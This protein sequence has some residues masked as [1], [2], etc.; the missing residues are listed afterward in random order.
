MILTYA[1]KNKF[2]PSMVQLK[3]KCLGMINKKSFASDKEWLNEFKYDL[4]LKDLGLD[5]MADYKVRHEMIDFNFIFIIYFKS[6]TTPKTFSSSSRTILLIL[7]LFCH[8][9]EMW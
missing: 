4:T 7:L 5:E 6:R 3:Q 9:L 1:Q 2:I 8:T